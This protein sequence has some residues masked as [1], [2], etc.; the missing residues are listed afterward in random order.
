MPLSQV[1]RRSEL[2]PEELLEVYDKLYWT[3]LVVIEDYRA[4]CDRKHALGPDIV[5]ELQ[6]LEDEDEDDETR[7]WQAL[8]DPEA[9]TLAN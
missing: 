4:G 3:R 1:S 6:A 5:D 8:F 7:S 2:N 9:F